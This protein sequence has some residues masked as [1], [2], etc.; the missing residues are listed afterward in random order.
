MTKQ[1]SGRLRTREEREDLLRQLLTS[2]PEQLTGSR[3]RLSVSPVPEGNILLA[4]ALHAAA[5]LDK[6]L[7]LTGLEQRLV[8]ML[9]VALEDDDEVAAFGR[10]YGG[11]REQAAAFPQ[12][13]TSRSLEDGLTFADVVSEV[14]A[15]RKSICAQPMI[16]IRDISTLDAGESVI[17]PDQQQ[18][19]PQYAGGVT[20]LT[21][22]EPEEKR[23]R[24]RPPMPVHLKL[25]SFQCLESS[26]DVF[27]G[28]EDEIYWAIASGA[29]QE[30]QKHYKT[31]EF[32][33]VVD[34]SV[35]WFS[36]GQ[37]LYVGHVSEYLATHVE[38]WEA[39]DSDGGFYNDLIDA[40]YGLS[41]HMLETCKT[42]QDGP[43][44][45]DPNDNTE[46]WAALL[47]VAAILVAKL[48]E[49]IRNDDDLVTEHTLGFTREDLIEWAQS[50]SGE[51]VFTFDG[52][53]TGKHNL[54]IR[55]GAATI[56]HGWPG[57]RGTAFTSGIDAACTVASNSSD[58]YFFRGDRYV[59][60]NPG[61]EKIVHHRTIADGFP[62][63]R[64]TT[65]TSSISAA[66]TVPASNSN[67]YLFQGARCI[68]YDNAGERIVYNKTITDAFPGLRG[69]Q[70]A[71][72][73]DAACV[74]PGSSIH[75]YFFRGN[76]CIRYDNSGEKVIY[77]ELITAKWPG[78]VHTIFSG[79]MDT[80]CNVPSAR[81]STLWLF[82]GDRYQRYPL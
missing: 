6:G 45:V 42:L 18:A 65:F 51:R 55:A 38:C 21:R 78:L 29:D 7:E 72:G 81:G 41:D 8:G 33:S 54:H 62:G 4:A 20:V 14:N 27:L 68:R 34:G 26:G 25:Q 37:S 39:D 13:V 16:Q 30:E 10:E 15:A 44:N 75:L 56:A 2:R 11:L 5:R 17:G 36:E 63:L 57:L 82:K 40:M 69:T 59:R 3:G 9:Q 22:P 50:D 47:H 35:R 76:R 49:L 71:D 48:L 79:G 58:V 12:M 77:N 67:L 73:I 52:G 80:A 61:D 66:S 74:V 19:M 24:G 64:G 32:G 70:F 31:G 23:E 1:A 46:A 53:T 60:Y 28:P 43:P